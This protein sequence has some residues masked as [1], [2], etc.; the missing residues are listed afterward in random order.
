MLTQTYAPKLSPSALET[1]ARIISLANVDAILS[2][3]RDTIDDMREIYSLYVAMACD[4]DG[5]EWED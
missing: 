2:N 3:N 5:T 1:L 4:N